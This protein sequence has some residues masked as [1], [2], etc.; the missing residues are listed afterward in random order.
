MTYE[1]QYYD[2]DGLEKLSDELMRLV[3]L[4][5]ISGD[6]KRHN[7]AVRCFKS[8]WWDTIS[9]GRSHGESML[10]ALKRLAPEVEQTI[11]PAPTK[12][13]IEAPTRR[14]DYMTTYNALR[15]M[16]LDAEGR[17]RDC[18]VLLLTA[19]EMHAHYC[20]DCLTARRRRAADWRAAHRKQ[21]K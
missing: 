5:Y 10:R 11:T 12:A 9:L 1:G 15:R 3:V 18:T 20:T 16:R 8:G 6:R 21:K 13:S 14:T 4:D 19:A 17:C 2:D 7:D